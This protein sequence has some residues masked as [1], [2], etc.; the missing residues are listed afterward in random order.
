MNDEVV[1]VVDPGSSSVKAG[2]SGD[3]VPICV[4]PS[5]FSKSKTRLESIEHEDTNTHH[6]SDYSHPI[7]RGVVNDWDNIEK[8][9]YQIFDELGVKDTETMSIMLAEVLKLISKSSS[10]NEDVVKID[11]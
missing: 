5:C 10:L 8:L 11:H 9:W 6:H 7:H 4:F 3:D 1:I 2:Y